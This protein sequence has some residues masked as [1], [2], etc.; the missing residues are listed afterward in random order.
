MAALEDFVS[1]MMVKR[2]DMELGLFQRKIKDW[3][4]MVDCVM[5]DPA[6]R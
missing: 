1:P 3:R 2:L 6:Y 4:S 5:S